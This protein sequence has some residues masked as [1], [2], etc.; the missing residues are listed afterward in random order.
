MSNT[1]SLVVRILLNVP[2]DAVSDSNDIQADVVD[3][4][5]RF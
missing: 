2:A 3:I 5:A 4:S 1:L